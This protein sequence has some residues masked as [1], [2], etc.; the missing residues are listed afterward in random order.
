[1]KKRKKLGCKEIFSFVSMYLDKELD[2]S[3]CE[4]INRHMRNCKP[5]KVFLNTLHK[6]IKLCKKFKPEEIPK[7]QKVELRRDL[8][9]ELE[10]FRK[11]VK[12]TK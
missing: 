2:D 10:T 3:L 4:E 8:E 12:T 11:F 7:I 6:T 5:C 9:K 1:M